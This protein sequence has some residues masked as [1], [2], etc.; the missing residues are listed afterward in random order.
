MKAVTYLGCAAILAFDEIRYCGANS[1][2]IMRRMRALLQDLTGQVPP[3]QD[4]QGLGLWREGRQ[5]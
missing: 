1:I 5:E 3:E 4:R 2:Q